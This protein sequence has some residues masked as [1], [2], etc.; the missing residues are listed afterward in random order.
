MMVSVGYDGSRYKFLGLV[1]IENHGTHVV[2]YTVGADD[3]G[4]DDEAWRPK[5]LIPWHLR[6]DEWIRSAGAYISVW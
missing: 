1:E 6:T 4:A 2:V 3:V 5:L